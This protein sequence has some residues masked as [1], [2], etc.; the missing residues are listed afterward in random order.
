[1]N[2]QTASNTPNNTEI[3]AALKTFETKNAEQMSKDL[4]AAPV[5][6]QKA[7]EGVRFETDSYKAIKFYKET[8]TP[9]VVKLTMKW[10]GGA[11][12]SK[13]QAEYVL[14]AFVIIAMAVSFYLF[15]RRGSRVSPTILTPLQE[16]KL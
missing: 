6:A 4:E 3:D 13:R 10:S 15:F 2:E 8:D 9:K 11:I 16:G 1:M 5:V 14:F 12:K 7:V